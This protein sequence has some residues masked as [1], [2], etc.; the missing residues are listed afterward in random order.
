MARS[1]SAFSKRQDKAIDS[2]ETAAEEAA[3][4]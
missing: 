3:D 1:E 4:L 2:R